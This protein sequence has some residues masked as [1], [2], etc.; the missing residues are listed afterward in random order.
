MFN[1]KIILY[2]AI[3]FLVLGCFINEVEGRR[4]ILRGRKT[5][6][7]QYYRGLAIPAWTIVLLSGL[8]MLTVGGGLY[9]VLKKVVVDSSDDETT[10]SYHPA[11]Q[12]DV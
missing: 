2:L 3:G 12:D 8:A 11:I 5:I 1:K 4:K 10:N 7:R 6:T 9:M